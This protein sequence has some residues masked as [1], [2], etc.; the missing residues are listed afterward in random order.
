[1][2]DADAVEKLILESEQDFQ[3]KNRMADKKDQPRIPD[4]ELAALVGIRK[5]QPSHF[6]VIDAADNWVIDVLKDVARMPNQNEWQRLRDG[7]LDG[8][9]GMSFALQWRFNFGRLFGV[10]GCDVEVP[11]PQARDV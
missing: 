6:A 5:L 8:V 1:M 9:I 3:A 2:R 4:A 7:P 10:K 11:M